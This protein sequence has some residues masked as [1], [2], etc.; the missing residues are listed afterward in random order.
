[1][2][3][4]ESCIL[5]DVA[6]QGIDLQDLGRGCVEVGDDGIE[7]RDSRPRYEKIKG[8]VSS[9]MLHVRLKRKRRGPT[10][11]AGTC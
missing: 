4:M 11:A 10:I 7:T 8:R 3:V 6:W 5:T 2:V 9:F 1:M